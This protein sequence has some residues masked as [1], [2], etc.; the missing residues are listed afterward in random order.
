MVDTAVAERVFIRP[1]LT[2]ASYI[3]GDCLIERARLDVT[4]CFQRAL[5]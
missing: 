3:L 2:M 5:R 4:V 1:R